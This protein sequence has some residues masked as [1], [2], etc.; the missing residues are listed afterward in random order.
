MARAREVYEKYLRGDSL[1][2]QDVSFGR[3]YFRE[4]AAKLSALGPIFHLA[5]CEANR[6]AQAF[7]GFF[8]ARRRKN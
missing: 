4:T 5:W 2:D 1:T 3:T 8:V 6:A 7:D